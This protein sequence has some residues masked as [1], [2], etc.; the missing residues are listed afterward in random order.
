M[1]FFFGVRMHPEQLLIFVVVFAV[2]SIALGMYLGRRL[3]G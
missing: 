1:T 2:L 3:R